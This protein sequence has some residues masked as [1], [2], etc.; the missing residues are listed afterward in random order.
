MVAF[1]S[2]LQ[3]ADHVEIRD[4][5][6]SITP[7]NGAIVPPDWFKKHVDSLVLQIANR[8]NLEPMKY[9]DYS[10]GI[11]GK[12]FSGLT[13]QFELLEGIEQRYVIFNVELNRQRKGPNG[14]GGERY[15]GKQFAVGRRSLFY[16]FWSHTKLKHPQS[17]TVYHDY[18]GNLKKLYFVA[19][20]RSD[21]RLEAGTLRPLN[22]S[23]NTILR[24]FYPDNIRTLPELHPDKSQISN[25]DKSFPQA[26]VSQGAEPQST[27]CKYNYETS[28]Q[29][30]AGTRGMNT[31]P[32]ATHCPQNQQVEEWLENYEG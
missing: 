22:A 10:T 25:P 32:I 20:N 3:R 7:R 30:S 24:A 9:V 11:Y 12:R 19:E 15:P 21:G 4:G 29:G 16:R 31:S 5:K 28:N 23:F 17:V 13:L 27:T 14:T 6:L 26:Q 8:L 1:Q 2:V 18:M